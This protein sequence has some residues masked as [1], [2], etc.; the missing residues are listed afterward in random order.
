ME[1]FLE[2]LLIGRLLIFT[3][4]ALQRI[5]YIFAIAPVWSQDV[6]QTGNPIRVKQET[7]PYLGATLGLDFAAGKPAGP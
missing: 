4:F 1:D 5:E 3:D 2:V 6:R 7:A